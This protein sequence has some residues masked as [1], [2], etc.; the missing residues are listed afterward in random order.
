MNTLSTT[1]K[2]P[3]DNRRLGIIELMVITA[4]I[5]IAFA[6]QRG[7]SVIRHLPDWPWRSGTV[8]SFQAMDLL[9]ASVYGLSLAVFFLAVRSPPFWTSPGKTLALLF[10]NMCVLDWTLDFFASS[11]VALRFW[12]DPQAGN[13]TTAG[14]VL[15]IWY[16]QFSARLGYILGL[17]VLILAIFKSKPQHFT[18]RLAW[19]GFLFFDLAIL[20]LLHVKFFGGLPSSLL[21]WYFPITLGVPVVMLAIAFV[22]GL[23]RRELDWWTVLTCL[24][25][26]AIWLIAVVMQ[27]VGI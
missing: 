6:I 21:N 14:Y 27:G 7:L 8:Q 13:S 25:V 9:V 10:A 3:Q 22:R 11:T 26:M 18:W 17:P 2:L 15:G 19:G 20:A 4:G 24:P 16:E 12:G 23:A 1:G 5:A